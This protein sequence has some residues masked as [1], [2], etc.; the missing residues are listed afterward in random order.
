TPLGIA[1]DPAGRYI[2]VAGFY[3]PMLYKIDIAAGAIAGSIEIGAS[4]SGVAVTA[5]G[6]LIVTADR[7]DNQISLIDAKTFTRK[8]IVKV[9]A[10]PFGV[11]IDPQGERAYTAN[12]ESNDVSVVDLAAGTLIGTVATGKRPYAVA[13]AKGRGFASDQYGGTVSVF[14]LVSLQPL[15]RIP[16]GEYP[17]G[18]ES[19]ADGS[20]IYVVNWF[21]N[22]V[23]TINAET[24]AV[25]AKMP[26]GD[27]PRAFGTFLREAL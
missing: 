1:A 13:L 12:V 21:S 9:G 7:D 27:G 23:W 4:P 3:Q 11:T 24:L 5:D 17:E 20:S 10:H 19:S 8:G 22:D 2:Y 15:K 14:D 26:A 18:I 16:V 6:A 25:T